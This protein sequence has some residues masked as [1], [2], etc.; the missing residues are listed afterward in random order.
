MHEAGSAEVAARLPLAELCA[1]DAAVQLGSFRAAGEALHLTA[2]AIS[3]RIKSLES[4]L[5]VVLFQRQGRTLA[6][7]DAGSRLAPFARDGFGAVARGLAAI[8]QTPRARQ[9]RVSALALFNQ[10]ILVPR[11]GEFTARYPE[12]DVRIQAAT[13]FV[14]FEEED[15]D[16]A[17]RVGNGRWPGLTSVEL[18][19]ISGMPVAAPDMLHRLRI[20]N[21]ADLVSVR[22]IHDAA[23][24][25]AWRRWLA[26]QGIAERD[27]SGDLWFDSAPMTLHAA[28]QGLGVALAIDPLVRL[29]PGFGTSLKQAIP[30]ATGPF[31]RYWIVHR[32]NAIREPKVRAFVAWVTGAC[33]ALA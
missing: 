8:A 9:I 5:G 2:S 22:L 32:P 27:E 24:P 3:H 15:I 7:T 20:V 18:L 10:T 23:Q 16:V 25:T 29:W 12:F 21:P 4:K 19:R 13:H 14:D 11:L 6:L 31:S 30:G 33:A 17:I 26:A 1:F 28:E